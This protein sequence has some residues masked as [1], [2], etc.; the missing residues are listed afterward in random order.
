MLNMNKRRLCTECRKET[1]YYLKK[2]PIEK[3]IRG[4]KYNFDVTTA[5]C[6]NCGATMG[7]P[8]IIDLNVKEIDEQYRAAEGIVSTEDINRLMQLYDIGKDP[9][10]LALGFGQVTI[11]RY[12]KGQ[13]P[14]KNHSNIIRRALSSPSFM[15][16]MLAANR[17]KLTN[18][19]Y[20]KAMGSVES[21]E[22]LFSVS[23]KMLRVI[24][25]LFHC[26][27]E[28]TPL[29][30]QKLLY[31]VQGIHHSIHGRFIFEEDCQAWAHGP[32]YTEVY[33]IFRSFSFNPI[34]DAR[35]AI[36]DGV[37]SALTPEEQHTI[38]LVTNTFGLYGGKFL[39]KI[40]H[41]EEPWKNARIGYENNSPAKEIISKE[42]IAIYFKKISSN[43]DIKTENGIK[44]YIKDIAH[45]CF[46]D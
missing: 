13:V 19:A 35:F 14:S 38:D 23:G 37:D 1:E 45:K 21:I 17:E 15:R 16:Q 40:T 7:L 2:I 33:N 34:E 27:K 8:G 12:M 43:Y 18:T 32:V 3:S 22:K 20:K 9:L 31:Y 26:L 44:N 11:G 4:Q 25:Y 30:L 28:I 41:Q 6:K 24:A 36:L 39:E 10:S 5:I 42:S 46:S 29:A